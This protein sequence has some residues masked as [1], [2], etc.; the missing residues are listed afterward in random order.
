MTLNISRHYNEV[1]AE[2]KAG[3]YAAAVNLNLG[4]DNNWGAFSFGSD[5]QLT[6]DLNGYNL[7][8]G[9]VTTQAGT[10]GVYKFILADYADY[11]YN[12]KISNMTL[13]EI[14][15][16]TFYNSSSTALV[17][18]VDYFIIADTTNGG[19]WINSTIPEPAEWAAIFG[20]LALSLAIWRKRA[21]RA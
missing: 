3:I 8:L 6:L 5:T 2:G 21:K 14:E 12:F 11:D 19:Y 18:G 20:A 10:S 4:A 16:L 15:A 1:T 9:E 13:T 17:E 7:V